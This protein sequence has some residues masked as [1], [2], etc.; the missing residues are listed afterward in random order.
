MS[1]VLTSHSEFKHKKHPELAAG[2]HGDGAEQPGRPDVDADDGPV[3]SDE[4]SASAEGES[5]AT[6]H[7][8]HTVEDEDPDID[9]IGSSFFEE[10]IDQAELDPWYNEG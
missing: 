5:T 7:D 4:D 10:A 8:V 2:P 3:V 6:G 9:A 1:D